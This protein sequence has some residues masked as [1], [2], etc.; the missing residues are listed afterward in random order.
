MS[1]PRI[2]ILQRAALLFDEWVDETAQVRASRLAA[3]AQDEPA[4]AHALQRLFAAHERALGQTGSE[5][6]ATVGATLQDFAKAHETL[7]EG[8]SVGPFKVIRL[9]GVGGMGQVYLGGR[10]VDGREQQVAIKLP[11][12]R[13]APAAL[14][15]FRAERA[16]LASLSHPAIARLVDAGS[17]VAANPGA[18][19]ADH[20]DRPY[21]AMEYVDGISID[22]YANAQSL[23][24]D[25]RLL[26]VSQLLSGLQYAHERLIVHRD[27][28]A[29]NVLVDA[30]SQP[31]IL[32]FGIGKALDDISTSTAEGQRYFS[33]A[34]AAPEQ[35]RGEPSSAATDVY[36][37]GVL[38][39]E[40]LCGV[41]PL[42][43]AELSVPAAL[44]LAMYGV[45]PLASQRFAA[46]P[47]DTQT[48]IAQARQCSPAQLKSK[49]EGDIDA[50]LARALRKEPEQ[51]YAT[52]RAFADDIA[53]VRESRP[54]DA[55][56]GDR[57]YRL[58]RFLK[59]HRL[60]AGLS[61]LT[62]LVLVISVAVLWRQANDLRRARDTS[63]QVADF[64]SDML[65]QV[66]PQESG[67]RLGETV[68]A[69]IEAL[70]ADAASEEQ[71]QAFKQLWFQ[72]NATDI[73]ISVVDGSILTPAKTAIAEQFK[74][75]PLVDAALSHALAEAY[76]SIGLS[77]TALPLAQHA[78]EIQSRL[79]GKKGE[80]IESLLTKGLILSS[81]GRNDEAEPYFLDFH[82]SMLQA[83]GPDHP[84]TIEG[85]VYLGFFLSGAGRDDEAEP[86]Y[87]EALA[88]RRNL[89]GE[90]DPRTLTAMNNY[91]SLLTNQGQ[92]EAA[93]RLLRE[94]L[95]HRTAVLGRD[96]RNTITTLN[97]LAVAVHRLGRT[98]EGLTL[99][100]S[101]LAARRRVLGSQ[102]P[103]TLRT[104]GSVASSLRDLGRHAEAEIS[105]REAMQNSE[106]SLGPAHQNTQAAGRILALL[107]L[108]QD[109][110]TEAGAL[111]GR[112]NAL[113]QNGVPKNE[114]LLTQSML[115]GVLIRL[116]QYAEAEVLLQNVLNQRR[117]LLGDEHF[118]TIT[119]TVVFARLRVAQGRHREALELLVPIETKA[120]ELFNGGH[121][122]FL[123]RY[124]L[125]FGSAQAALG[126]FAVAEAA[127]T[128]SIDIWSRTNYRLPRDRIDRYKAMIDLYSR[129]SRAE[130]KSSATQTLQ[131]WRQRL[132]S[133]EKASPE[134]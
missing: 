96:H 40:L 94:T 28:K 33:L 41:A 112:L 72:L 21:L 55:R 19:A 56:R 54:I 20:Q 53:A 92:F 60:A 83:Y 118:D 74:D 2:G 123:S 50:I 58:R 43:L 68:L 99:M 18:N 59:R 25:A 102:H 81:L 121:L 31:R 26:L 85:M 88:R 57:V 91:G 11:N 52:A 7:A 93:E 76:E 86:Y 62:A 63:Q 129:W 79:L 133:A 37:C 48:K 75:Q 97:N 65:G 61:T 29:E 124:L 134:Q 109:K 126:N 90:R 51:R 101:A 69:A 70:P 5:V 82:N 113:P 44:E 98:E 47:L 8:T 13:A 67:Q 110:L 39:Y 14:A 103:L 87:K 130:P 38:L 12:R 111:L 84:E 73:A 115:G 24:M 104:L 64:Q 105:A 120:R 6:L 95:D 131:E 36:A 78:V 77:E 125:S 3:I 23:T 116:E 127:L 107:L 117:H 9:L 15:R 71:R 16:M 114:T 4:L 45:P 128:E 89:F 108:D 27:I 80:T 100:Q 42:E 17:F 34:S 22:A 35:I 49:L 1:A 32:D 30:S 10:Q 132:A 46:L 119:S 106:A 66:D 122:H